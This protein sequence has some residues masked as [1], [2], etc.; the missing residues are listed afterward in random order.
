MDCLKCRALTEVID[1]LSDLL[2]KA[3]RARRVALHENLA[4]RH[5]LVMDMEEEHH[6]ISQA[7][8]FSE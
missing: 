6:A 7:D 2:A 8:G 4:L 5:L 3:Q 1:E